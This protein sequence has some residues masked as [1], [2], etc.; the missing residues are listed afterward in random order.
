MTK[1]T[2]HVKAYAAQHNIG[3][4]AAMIAAKATYNSG[5]I[6]PA[7]AEAFKEEAVMLRNKFDKC[8]T[9]FR[10]VKAK[11]KKCKGTIPTYDE[12]IS[13]PPTYNDPPLELPPAYDEKEEEIKEPNDKR[14]P[15]DYDVAN[16]PE[17]PKYNPAIINNGYR[18]GNMDGQSVMQ[19]SVIRDDERRTHDIRDAADMWIKYW[20]KRAI[21]EKE[22]TNRLIAER[23][24]AEYGYMPDPEVDVIPPTPE[25]I[26]DAARRDRARAMNEA[27]RDRYR[28]ERQARAR[29]ARAE[30]QERLAAGPALSQEER[31]AEGVREL[32]RARRRR[33][34]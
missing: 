1:W 21:Y 34:R 9:K 23:F 25:E 29:A 22:I 5:K 15:P 28:E 13:K 6:T 16:R 26:R 10:S 27:R 7:Q 8:Q 2:D 14:A 33:A 4:K 31:L 17:K 18:M 19:L 20:I 11:Y 30:I 3:Y 32:S 24:F 12:A